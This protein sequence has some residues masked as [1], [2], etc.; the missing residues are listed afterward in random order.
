MKYLDLISQGKEES[1]KEDLQFRAEEAQ[2]SVSISILE[3]RKTLASL[4]KQLKAAQKAI[5][6]DLQT[7]VD[8]TI[9]IDNLKAGLKIAKKIETDRF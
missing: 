4:G 9:R 1:V 5:P 8:L 6:Y 7:E 2:H 3:T